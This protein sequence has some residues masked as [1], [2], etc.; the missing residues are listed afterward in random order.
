M[1]SSPDAEHPTPVS[2]LTSLHRQQRVRGK[3][4][5]TPQPRGRD[6]TRYELGRGDRHSQRVTRIYPRQMYVMS[7]AAHRSA[8][9]TAHHASRS[10]D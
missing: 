1:S 7:A 5:D 6:T 2:N 8:W 10:A 4:Q 3:V 9:V